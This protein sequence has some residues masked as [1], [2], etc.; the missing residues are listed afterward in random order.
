MSCPHYCW[1]EG[2]IFGDYWCN[3]NNCAVDSD[4]YYKYCRNHSYDECPNYRKSESTGGCFITTVTCKILGAPDDNIILKILRSFRDGVLQKDKAYAEILKFYDTVGPMIAEYL[5]ADENRR[6]IANNIYC[7][8][9][10]PISGSIMRCQYS[11]AIEQ[12]K[13]LTLWLIEYCKLEEEYARLK[14]NDYEYY[15][16]DQSK[17][18]HGKRRIRTMVPINS[19]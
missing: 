9:L 5:E 16:F 18:G 17:A 15:D 19:N 11:N 8:Y 2:L 6:E 7:N 14:A 4:T 1:K 3:K 10:V 12:Y 13:N